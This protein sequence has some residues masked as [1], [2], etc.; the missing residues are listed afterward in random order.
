MTHEEESPIQ[1]AMALVNQMMAE[2]EIEEMAMANSFVVLTTNAETHKIHLN[3]PFP[4]APS[5]LAWAEESEEQLNKL[6]APDEEPYTTAV[7]PMLSPS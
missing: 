2:G 1:A 4:D 6:L 3:G 7:Y 5:A